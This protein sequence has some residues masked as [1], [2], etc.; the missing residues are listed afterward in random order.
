M[1]RV[2]QVLNDEISQLLERL[3][4]TVPDG[5]LEATASRN[6]VLRRRLDEV[7]SQMA[8]VRAALIDSYSRWRRS[9]DD[10]ENIWALAAWKAAGEDTPYR[11][12]A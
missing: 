12:C 8:T 10:L 5:C 9:L 3:S 4:G 2:E 11:E 6:P 1:S 7:E